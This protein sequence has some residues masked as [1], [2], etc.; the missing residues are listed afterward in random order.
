M[1]T[2]IPLGYFK[3]RSISFY[4]SSGFVTSISPQKTGIFFVKWKFIRC[5]WTG[6][7]GSLARLIFADKRNTTQIGFAKS[8]LPSKSISIRTEFHL[9][10][11]F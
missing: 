10:E 4:E 3:L 9:L 2:F 1:Y 5:S 7:E 6:I 8:L 11:T